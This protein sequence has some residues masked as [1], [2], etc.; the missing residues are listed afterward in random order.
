VRGC[1]RFTG[2]GRTCRKG[3]WG[4][5]YD[6]IYTK[7]E[8]PNK[9]IDSSSPGD[10][11]NSQYI[12]KFDSNIITYSLTFTDEQATVLDDNGN[13]VTVTMNGTVNIGWDFW[14]NDPDPDF[15]YKMIVYS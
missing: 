13:N 6:F 14:Y 15:K 9:A 4:T 8:N 11:K 12:D 7:L 10:V 3:T 2:T 1:E 5:G